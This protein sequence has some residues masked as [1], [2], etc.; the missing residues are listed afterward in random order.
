MSAQ[1]PDTPL[2]LMLGSRHLVLDRPRIMGILNTTP[3]S[4]SDGGRWHAAEAAVEHALEMVASGADIVDVGGE[5]TRPGASGVSESEEI[6][7]VVP[8]IEA[9]RAVSEVPISVDTSKPG[10]MRA[11][12]RAGA[13]MINDVRALRE[14][15]ALETAV[16]LGLPVCLMH[17]QGQ[18]RQMQERP[19]YEDV[20]AEVLAFL[21]AR[22]QAL[23]A[24]GRADI[25]V[26]IDPGFGFGKT[27]AHNQALFRALPRFV[28]T[29][30]PVLVGVSR[31]SM[32]GAL[33]GRDTADRVVAS[34]VAAAL[35]ACR[36][37]HL[38]RVHDVAET[39]DALAVVAGLA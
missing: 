36:G 11:A 27:L 3:D 8:V 33:T 2:S 26:V 7:R 15:G 5:S 17:M 24:A 28:D 1:T 37:V 13:N 16:E 21:M 10:V 29:G 25:D 4:F 34:T 32:L 39:R 14:P 19:E 9:L 35:A 38:L 30:L 6:E 23:R 20:A 31:K 12:A 22:V 18:P